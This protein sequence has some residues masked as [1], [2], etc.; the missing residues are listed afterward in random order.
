MTSTMRMSLKAGERIYINGAVLQV[1]RKVSLQLLNNATF[2]LGVHVLQAEDATTPM[3]QLYFVAQT[4]L[5]DP[6]G[7][8]NALELFVKFCTSLQA[9]HSLPEIKTELA[10]IEG[11][12]KSGNTFAAL[13]RIRGLYA[14]EDQMIAAG[15]PL[16]ALAIN[17]E[18]KTDDGT[19]TSWTDLERSRAANGRQFT[20]NS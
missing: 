13:K 7:E 5:I 10:E 2:L 17:N 15:K 12:V 20:N 14:L 11:Q 9:S 19:H 8:G 4:L 6:Q 3:R 1:D 18:G 16:P